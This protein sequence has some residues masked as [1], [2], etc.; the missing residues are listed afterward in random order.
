MTRQQFW[1]GLAMVIVSLV[2]TALSQ[3]PLDGAL[4]FVT[5]VSAI[6]G[7]VGK[8]LIFA[9][10]TTT[11]LAKIVS[12]ALVALGTGI[13]ESVGLILVEHKIIWLVFLKVVGSILLTYIGVSLLAPPSA[14]SKQIKKLTLFKSVA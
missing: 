12:G 8:N 4:L 1:K 3:V 14:E 2:L 10:A 7:Y 5:A 13:T 9:F 6:L 11:V